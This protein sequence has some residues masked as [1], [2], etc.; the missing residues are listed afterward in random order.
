M[1]RGDGMAN[2]TGQ[3]D[4]ENGNKKFLMPN[5]GGTTAIDFNR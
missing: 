3:Y 5:R 2:T 4:V 1:T